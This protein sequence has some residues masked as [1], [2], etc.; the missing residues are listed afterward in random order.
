MVRHR[1]LFPSAHTWHCR[2][3]RQF[4][5]D[6]ERKEQKETREKG[7]ERKWASERKRPPP[8]GN[9]VGNNNRTDLNG[10]CV[11]RS[12]LVLLLMLLHSCCIFL[13]FRQRR[14]L[15]ELQNARL[16]PYNYYHQFYDV[17]PFRALPLFL[18]PFS[19]IPSPSL[20]LSTSFPDFPKTSGKLAHF[21]KFKNLTAKRRRTNI[22]V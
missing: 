12:L 18:F 16:D 21:Q 15:S 1:P 19:L 7:R 6:W 17:S 3:F 5:H 11:L 22:R 8:C 14:T 10:Y 2:V 9:S 4:R 13:Q 20:S